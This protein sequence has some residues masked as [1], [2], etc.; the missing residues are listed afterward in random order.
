MTLAIPWEVVNWPQRRS[1]IPD[2]FRNPRD[3]I[4]YS[5]PWSFY[6]VG[7]VDTGKMAAD[8]AQAT[9][10]M[11]ENPPSINRDDGHNLTVDFF[12]SDNDAESLTWGVSPYK[13]RMAV[14]VDDSWI[15]EVP[16]PTIRV[17]EFTVEKA[18]QYQVVATDKVLFR[19]QAS[20]EASLSR[21][22]QVF[23]DRRGWKQEPGKP[24]IALIVREARKVVMAQF[25]AN[26]SADRQ[27]AEYVFS[28]MNAQRAHSGIAPIV[29][30]Q[31]YM[32]VHLDY[33]DL[34]TY[35][36]LKGFGPQD[37]ADSLDWIFK[38]TTQLRWLMTPLRTTRQ[39]WPD[40]LRVMPIRQFVCLDRWNGISQG[41]IGD[42]PWLKFKGFDL[43][44][45]LGIHPAF[46][47]PKEETRQKELSPGAKDRVE[48]HRR[49]RDMEAKRLNAKDIATQLELETG[50]RWT[51]A[52][53][54]YHMIAGSCKCDEKSE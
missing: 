2:Q 37:I 45:T 31:R 17:S 9:G 25:R 13:D 30:N 49:I 50:Q 36:V 7:D 24:I 43:A 41:V 48:K 15:G 34:A 16:F 29:D 35:R 14:I 21:L 4:D 47:K 39:M 12:G 10:Y 20:H 27:E 5:L 8:L 40:Y 3:F 22:F 46:D 33:R 54:Y 28:D 38:P 19:G 53:V 26:M 52:S 6:N 11:E 42:I 44:E 1:G 18:K 51:P 23:R 32:G